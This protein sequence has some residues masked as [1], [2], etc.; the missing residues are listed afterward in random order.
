MKI[1]DRVQYNIDED[2]VKLDRVGTVVSLLTDRFIMIKWDGLKH[3]Q[4]IHKERLRVVGH[5][6]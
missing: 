2:T 5:V 1:G 4:R 6:D 3:R